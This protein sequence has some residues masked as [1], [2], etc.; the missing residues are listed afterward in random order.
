[1][2]SVLHQCDLLRHVHGRVGTLRTSTQL[3][4]APASSPF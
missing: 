4:F 2:E 1:M 3:C